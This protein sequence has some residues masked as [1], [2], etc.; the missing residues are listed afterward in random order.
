MQWLLLLWSTGSRANWLCSCDSR[1]PEHRFSSW[2][3]RPQLFHGMWDLPG[4]GFEPVSPAQAGGL[5]TT[6]PPGKPSSHFIYLFIYFKL[7]HMAYQILVPQPGIEPGHT[8]VKA[9][10]P[11]H[12]TTREVPP[13]KFSCSVVSTLWDPMDC[14]RPGLPIHHQLP[15][16][17]KTHVH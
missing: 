17:T 13:V 4:A 1:A 10:S 16:F 7:C 2:G 11:S 9:P 15:R 14:S 5:F 12:W 3:A 6:E 8:A